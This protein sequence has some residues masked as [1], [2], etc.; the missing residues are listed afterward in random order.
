MPT[1][2][3]LWELPRL[4]L[5]KATKHCWVIFYTKAGHKKTKAIHTN[6]PDFIFTAQQRLPVASNSQCAKACFECIRKDEITVCLPLMSRLFRL[7]K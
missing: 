7:P 5:S 6:T 2:H 4:P 1:P 3:I